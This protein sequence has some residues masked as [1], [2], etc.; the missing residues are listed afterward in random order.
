MTYLNRVISTS[1]THN[2]VHVGGTFNVSSVFTG[3]AAVDILIDATAA[4]TSLHANFGIDSDQAATT[5][6]FEDVVVSANGSSVPVVQLNR[7]SANTSNVTAFSGPTITS[8]GTTLRTVFTPTG[9]GFANGGGTGSTDGPTRGG[10][11]W[12][13]SA[14]KKYL[15]RMVLAGSGDLGFELSFYQPV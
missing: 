8:P 5:T 11:E 9:V 2:E 13:L 6:L 12:I 14:G 4:T 15:F 7:D 1:A 3:T 10:T